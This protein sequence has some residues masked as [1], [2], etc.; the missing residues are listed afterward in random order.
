M[1]TAPGT[2]ILL[3]I[4]SVLGLVLLNAF[5]VAAEFSLVGARKTR[6]D[7]MAQNGDRKATLARPAVPSLTNV[8]SATQPGITLP[9]PGL[10]RR[11][12]RAG[13]PSS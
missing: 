7:E 3:S 10:L 2:P 9:P 5:F 11:G 13:G 4:L 12:Q 8:I 1:E 6:L